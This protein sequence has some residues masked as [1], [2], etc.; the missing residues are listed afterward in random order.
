M[1]LPFI[2]GAVLTMTLCWRFRRAGC[3]RLA[4][5]R[6]CREFG[7]CFSS[8][9]FRQCSGGAQRHVECW[10]CAVPAPFLAGSLRGMVS[11]VP[12][13][14]LFSRARWCAVWFS[15][16]ECQIKGRIASCCLFSISDRFFVPSCH[17]VGTRS[18]AHMHPDPPPY[19]RVLPSPRPPGWGRE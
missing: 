15:G 10:C 16:Y 19:S 11:V 9:S 1:W 8:L 2:R 3:L 4:Y 6:R 17:I 13:S 7:S 5:F 18:L 14:S 12:L